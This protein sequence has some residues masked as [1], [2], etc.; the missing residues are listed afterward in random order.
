MA[1]PKKDIAPENRRTR[2]VTMKVSD[3]EHEVLHRRAAKVFG[4]SGGYVGEYSR[5][6]LLSDWK[7]PPPPAR[8][9]EVIRELAAEIRR[10]GNNVNQLAHLAHLNRSLPAEKELQE[11]IKKLIETLEAVQAL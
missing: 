4:V 11:V 2:C 6:I 10:V 7:N 1:R 3:A 5:L 8:S 9:P